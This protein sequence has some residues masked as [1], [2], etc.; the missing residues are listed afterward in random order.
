M[1]ASSLNMKYLLSCF[2]L[3]SFSGKLFSQELSQD[4]LLLG[5]NM[6]FE[7]LM[8][9]D[10]VT[11]SGRP[12][13]A[14]EAPS[15]IRVIVAEQIERL[16]V[17]SLIDVL[18]YL[19]GVE[20][21]MTPDGVYSISMRGLRK[22][23]VILLLIDGHSFNDLYNG[24]PILD[25]P[26]DFIEKIEVIEG[27][28][29]AVYGTNAIAGVINIITKSD[30]KDVVI[31]GGTHGTYGANV[32]Y[33]F[34][35]DDFNMGT[36]L[37]YYSTDGPNQDLHADREDAK[38]WSLT[39]YDKIGRTKR[40]VEDVVLN[41]NMRYRS[42][43]VNFTGLMRERGLWVGPN[44]VLTNESVYK[45]NQALLNVSNEFRLSDR[46][47]ITPC[48][49]SSYVGVDALLQDAPDNY[50]S[51]ISNQVFENG[52][53]IKEE[54]GGIKTGGQVIMNIR[55]SAKLT[56]TSA[57][58]Y[59]L[60]KL[61]KYDLSRNYQITGDEYRGEFGN[62]DSVP[63]EQKGKQREVLAYYLSGN[64]KLKE[65]GVNAGVR[66]DSYSDFGHT[67]NPRIGITYPLTKEFNI[68]A[69]YGSAFRAPVFRELYDNTSIGN[70][71][72]IKG[73]DELKPET[74][75]T[76][77][78]LVDFTQ[79]EYLIRATG[80][81]SL[82]N[83]AIGIYDPRGN[84]GIGK[85]ENLG[86]I[87]GYGYSLE[88]VV[89]LNSKLEWFANFSQQFREFDWNTEIARRVDQVFYEKRDYCG[90]L[91]KNIPVIRINSG[92]TLTLG[93]LNVFVGANYGY[94]S[95]NNHRFYLEHSREVEIPEYYQLNYYVSYT[96]TER[97]KVFA[98]GNN[99]GDKYSDPDEST[100]I[101]AFGKK[102]L[103]QPDDTHLVGLKLTLK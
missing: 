73:N 13:K 24:R 25:M 71:I 82:N 23:G 70:E 63:F 16:G 46:L 78:L 48:I 26:V 18:K 68:K 100:N 61:F 4:T 42:L 102:G 60:Q 80:Y 77:E 20:P 89:T 29:S 14:T 3:C 31:R 22:D 87:T 44:Y 19:P 12:E 49:Y 92:L 81:Y 54:Y 9:I 28:A 53:L 5:G 69:L 45:K 34:T 62:Y 67:V 103:I 50:E 75:K 17:T 10:V 21:N 88:T 40:P 35:K 30:K 1:T 33:V 101:N 99:I 55:A 27:P 37:G 39:A 74:I 72:G 2:I 95:E 51:A 6:S 7:Q 32:N 56:L 76:A 96:L 83:D 98:S 97:L 86:K 85:Y 43:K 41:T 47:S 52:K 11:A 36:S 38:N 94:R 8:N 15:I 65:I 93:K 58:M 90:R 59:E 84:G 91:L 64:Y 66:L 79:K 57:S